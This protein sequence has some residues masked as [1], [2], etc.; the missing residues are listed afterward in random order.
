MSFKQFVLI[1]EQNG[2]F[3][4]AFLRIRGG[5]RPGPVCRSRAA[6]SSRNKREVPRQSVPN[7]SPIPAASSTKLNKAAPARQI[8][9]E[10]VPLG[11]LP[12]GRVALT[13]ADASSA[14]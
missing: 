8:Q 3:R 1:S 13:P 10:L 2:T 9:K 5:R 4:T 6:H 14:R 7:R 12:L 11:T